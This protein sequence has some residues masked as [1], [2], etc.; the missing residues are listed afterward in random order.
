LR[1]YY[2]QR[3]RQAN[4]VGVP[5]T[6]DTGH[7]EAEVTISALIVEAVAGTTYWDYVQENIFKRCGMTGS[8][9]YTRSASSV[10]GG[11]PAPSLARNRGHRVSS[12]A[13]DS[14]GFAGTS[15]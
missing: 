15:R 5:G 6:P 8:E 12:N 3:D 11:R 13:A 4:L 2:Q 7:E 9:F 1:T 10:S 14:F